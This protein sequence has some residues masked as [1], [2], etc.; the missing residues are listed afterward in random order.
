MNQK[1]VIAVDQ[2]NS[3]IKTPGHVFPS[4]YR[5]S[6]HLP[7]M[8]A[9]VLSYEGKEYTPISKRMAQKDDKTKDED[10]FRL[11]LIA[12]AKELTSNMDA[13]LG[14]PAGEC[15]EVE[16]LVGLPP[17]HCK[18]MG[19]RF[20]DYFKRQGKPIS[21][22]FNNVP[23]SI[24]ITDVHVYPQAFAAAITAREH[25]KN[26]RTV[27]IVDIGGYTVDLLQLTNMQPDMSVCTSLYHGTNTMFHRINER[28]RAKGEKNIP[29]AL[30]EDVLL[31]NVPFSRDRSYERIDLIG[32]SAK[33]FAYELIS[34]VSQYG[35][36][37]TENMTV[38]VGGGSI[39]LRTHIIETGLIAK[40]IFVDN[41]HANVEG[42][43][44]LYKNRS[45]ARLQ[46][47]QP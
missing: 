36:D 9:D 30:I 43:K 25:F 1:I 2:G 41:V 4:G 27:N 8:G 21:F 11:T 35:L 15:I 29:D 19:A 44:L 24:K 5:E 10:Y 18:E 3:N 31:G 45:A 37:L 42:Y 46:R 39:L 33:Q 17:L 40:P 22:M 12:I 7:N 32:A 28:I 14:K 13:F 34:E 47:T 23:M 20:A 6:G 26:A 38:F 16:L